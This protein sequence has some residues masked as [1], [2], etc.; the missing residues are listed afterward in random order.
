MINIIAIMGPSGVGKSSLQ[1]RLGLKKIVT[2]TTREKRPGEIDGVHYN[3]IQKETLEKMHA[4][5][6]M[7]EYTQY[8]GY[9]YGSDIDSINEKIE[10]NKIASIVLDANGIRKLKEKF[11]DRVL[12]LGIMASKDNCRENMV[13]R[14]ECAI[15]NRLHAYEVEIKEMMEL[16]DLIINNSR[17][18]WN[19]SNEIIKIIK[20]GI[21]R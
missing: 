2:W 21:H 12:V 11:P 8:K 4:E 13:T 1:E 14:G 6:K 7:L 17:L 19:R 3:F 20:Y 5:G 16:S 9:F 10:N 18:N 15:E